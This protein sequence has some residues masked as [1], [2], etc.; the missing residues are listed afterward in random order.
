[1]KKNKG[2]ISIFLL[3]AFMPVFADFFADVFYLPI[4]VSERRILKEKYICLAGDFGI[5]RK[6]YNNLKGH[7]HTGIDIKNPG[8]FSGA[9]EP[10]FACAN[11]VVLSVNSSRASSYVIVEHNL[12]SGGRVYSAYTHISDIMVS[13]GDSVNHLSVLGSFIDHQ[14]LDKWGEYLNHVHFEMLKA[15]PKKVGTAN[16]RDIYSSYSV[17]ITKKSEISKYFFNPRIFFLKE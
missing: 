9:I 5:W 11:G 4:N 10:V 17:D 16:N 2:L 7:Y 8:E 14:K 12:R 1:M 15:Y 3:I 13:P 6:P